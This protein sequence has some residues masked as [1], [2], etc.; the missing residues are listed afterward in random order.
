[1]RRV[2]PLTAIMLLLPWLVSRPTEAQTNT[3]VLPK[4]HHVA[5][6]PWTAIIPDPDKFA[7]PTEGA[8]PGYQYRGMTAGQRR[9]YEYIKEKRSAHKDLSEADQAMIRRL[10]NLRRWPETP[11]PNKFWGDFMRYMRSLNT[12]ELNL[13]QT[14]MLSELRSR[15]LVPVDRAMTPEMIRVRDYLNSGPFHARNWF[16]RTFGRVEPWM[17]GLYSGY[18]YDLRPAGPAANTYPASPFNGMTITYNVSGAALTEPTDKDGFTCFR[19]FK[20]IIQPG[21]LR[22]AGTVTQANGYGATV[23]VRVWAGSKEEKIS[24]YMERKGDGAVSKAY[25]VS[26]PVPAGTKSGGFIVRLDGSYSMGGG[27]RGLQV[28]ASLTQSEA[29]AAAERAAADAAWRAEVEDTLRRLGYENTPE[30]KALEEMR[31]ALRG[32]DAAWKQYVDRK[33]KE[34]GYDP[35]PKAVAYRELEEAMDGDGERWRR[36]KLAHDGSST[37]DAPPA[38]P[39]T[40]GP[41]PTGTASSTSTPDIGSVDLGTA[42]TNGV[43]QNSNSSFAGPTQVSCRYDFT[44]LPEGSTLVSIWSRDGKDVISSNRS[45]SGTGWV[46][47]SLLSGGTQALTPGAYSV[48]IKL[49]DKL[50]ARKSF[51]IKPR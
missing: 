42:V 33:Q 19:S 37:G 39:P 38:T 14:L 7:W 15:G 29:D 28:S 45:V 40:S 13:A 4:E 21:T 5:G 44:S 9:F 25:D 32:G 41:A 8:R 35:A 46:S 43:V 10:V 24:Y 2:L 34:L 16:E 49:G 22:V 51:T 20:G 36:Y 50:L 17:D 27:H 3:Y 31:T 48:T 6:K 18:G 47:F 12:T 23:T 1:M 11:R 30:G 26:V